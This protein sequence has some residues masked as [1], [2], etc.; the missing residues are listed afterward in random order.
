MPLIVE[1]SFEGG[2]RQWEGSTDDSITIGIEVEG[3]F[4]TEGCGGISRFPTAAFGD[5]AVWIGSPDIE[6]IVAGTSAF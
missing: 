4:P 3:V 1:A 2:G 6:L 5:D